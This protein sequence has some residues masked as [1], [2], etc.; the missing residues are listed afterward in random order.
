[1]GAECLAGLR[2]PAGL[3]DF[4]IRQRIEE[5]GFFRSPAKAKTPQE[6]QTRSFR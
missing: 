6:D 4:V 2:M 1:M 5:E 3:A